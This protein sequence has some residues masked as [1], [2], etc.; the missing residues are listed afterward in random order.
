MRCALISLQ[1]ANKT[2]TSGLPTPSLVVLCAWVALLTLLALLA[3]CPRR[4]PV[5]AGPDAAVRPVW[6]AERRLL[7]DGIPILLRFFPAKPALAAQIWRD[8]AL[9]DKHFNDYRPDSAI[10]RLN[11][12]PP[13]QPIAVVPPLFEAVKLAL[14]AHQLTGGAFDPT[15]RP[16]RQLWKDAAKT[17]RLPAGERVRA[18]RA[19][20]NCSEIALAPGT[21]LRRSPHVQLD[22]GGMIKGLLLDK[23]VGRLQAAGARAFLVQVGGETASFGRSPRGRYHVIG[24][25]HPRDP[26][27]EWTQIHDPGS[28]LSG[29]TSSN[30]HRPI[31]IGKQTYYHIFDARTGQPVDRH[32]LSV[33]VVF[34]QLGRA[35]LADALS[36]ACLAL[37]PRQAASQVRAAGGEMLMLVEGEAGIAEYVT[38]GWRDLV[39]HRK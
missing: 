24:I 30:A 18:A 34:R 1:V 12:A 8:L 25:E 9:A 5:S 19:A 6:Y 4:E 26:A 29:A 17:G 20:S 39:Y 2:Q 11:H 10:S 16:V 13:G 3:A 35:W 38:D 31:R 33:S 28:G 23:I 36:T 14:R 21:I 15:L 27:R 37:G 22:L 7:Y 32:T